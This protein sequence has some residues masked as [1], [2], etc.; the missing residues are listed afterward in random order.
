MRGTM[1]DGI[2]VAP[3]VVLDGNQRYHRCG[4]LEVSL[5]R[6]RWQMEE[7]RGYD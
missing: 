2:I 5:R 4:G 6:K 1:S 3:N 7:N